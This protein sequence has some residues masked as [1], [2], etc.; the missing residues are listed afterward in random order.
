M[1]SVLSESSEESENN[2][3]YNIDVTK[4]ASKNTAVDK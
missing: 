3:S 1:K 4:E 2:D